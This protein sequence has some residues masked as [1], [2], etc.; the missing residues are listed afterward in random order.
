MKN[1]LLYIITIVSAL[2]L[3]PQIA[4]AQSTPSIEV[5]F[6]TSPLFAN[7]DFKPLDVMT[8]WFRVTNNVSARPLIIEA[9]NKTGCESGPFCLANRLRLQIFKGSTELYNGT[10]AQFYVGGQIVIDTSPEESI[11]LYTAKVTFETDADDNNYQM[12][13][14]G[15]DLLVGFQG[16]QTNTQTGNEPPGLQIARETAVIATSSGAINISWVT[17]YPATSQVLYGLTSGGPYTLNLSLPNYGYPFAT[18]E[19]STKLLNHSV[20]LTGLTPGASYRYRVVSH[21][22]PAT[23][24]YEHEF[25]VPNEP[26]F[27]S[28][29]MNKGGTVPEYTQYPETAHV[30]QEGLVMQRTHSQLALNHDRLLT[31][32]EGEIES[33]NEFSSLPTKENNLSAGIAIGSIVLISL[34]LIRKRIYR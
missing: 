23:V 9:I 19:D 5:E 6:E 2:L 26:L 30:A 34:L 7:D 25:T 1:I 15:F 4:L 10:L 29:Q 28:G 8:R 3:I 27:A 24:S 20:L 31:R 32:R 11:T 13:V 16:A 21:A 22:S 14:T 18:V 17:D 12:L 33:A